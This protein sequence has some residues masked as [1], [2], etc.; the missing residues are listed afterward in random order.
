MRGM[1]LVQE[2]RA[3]QP[4]G[5]EIHQASGREARQIKVELVEEMI[6]LSSYRPFEGAWRV[7]IIEDADRM[8]EPAQNHFLN[9]LEE[10][11]SATMFVLLS[12]YPRQLLPTVRSRCQPVRFGALRQETVKQVL[13]AQRDLPESVA[14]AI[15]WRFARGRC[16]GRSILWTLAS[17]RS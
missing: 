1:S 10:P 11:P 4:P 15:V 3:W 17:A 14:G 6:D 13:L 9:T 5:C 2:D 8:R 12:E 7:F 16:R